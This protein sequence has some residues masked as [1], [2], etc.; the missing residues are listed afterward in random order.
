M[1]N[2]LTAPKVILSILF[3][4]FLLTS[5]L[6]PPKSNSPLPIISSEISEIDLMSMGSDRYNLLIR[7]SV[8]AQQSDLRLQFSQEIEGVCG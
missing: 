5:C 6:T 7:G 4:S 1:N 3:V 8:F 2:K